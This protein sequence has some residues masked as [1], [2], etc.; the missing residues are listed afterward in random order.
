VPQAIVLPASLPEV[1]FAEIGGEIVAVMF[2]FKV[3][4]EE[5]IAK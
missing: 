5:A 3:T 2:E 1:Y 4:L